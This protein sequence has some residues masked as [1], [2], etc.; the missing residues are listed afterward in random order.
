MNACEVSPVLLAGFYMNSYASNSKKQKQPQQ[1]YLIQCITNPVS[2]KHQCVQ[3]E[4][5]CTVRT[6]SHILLKSFGLTASVIYNTSFRVGKYHQ[7]LVHMLQ[8]LKLHLNK[9]F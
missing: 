2:Q 6:Q 3:V 5:S 1:L 9:S 7:W 8:F 4:S